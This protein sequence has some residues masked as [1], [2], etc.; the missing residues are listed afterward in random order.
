MAAINAT[1]YVFFAA[2]AVEALFD[3]ATL[4]LVALNLY[5]ISTTSVIHANLKILLES[6]SVGIL[7]VSSVRLTQILLPEW[8]GQVTMWGMTPNLF[9]FLRIIGIVLNGLVGYVIP[10]E[11]CYATLKVRSYE[12]DKSKCFSAACLAVIVRLYRLLCHWFLPPN[13][14]SSCW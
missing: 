1:A 10:L 7:L 13:S 6:Q 3:A 12:R 4:P 2:T 8:N 9:L 5:A 11:R 14:L